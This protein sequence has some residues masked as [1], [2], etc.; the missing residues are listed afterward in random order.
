MDRLY[1]NR[2]NIYDIPYD[3]DYDVISCFEHPIGNIINYIDKDYTDYYIAYA[4]YMGVY[5]KGNVRDNILQA[6]KNKF[7]IGI[8]ENKRLSYR[9]LKEKINNSVPILVG[10]NLKSIWYSEHYLKKNWGHWFTVCGYDNMGEIITILDNMQFQHTGRAFEMFRIPYN[11]INKA[12]S[13]Y[14]KVFEKRHSIMVFNRIK[15]IQPLEIL[16][17]ILEEYTKL[18]LNNK[19]NFKQVELLDTYK[20]LKNEKTINTD[21]FE[22][23]LK[24][25]IIN[26]NK[27]RRL[28][29][30]ILEKYMGI[31]NF[32]KKMIE[33]YIENSRELNNLWE[34]FALRSVAGLSN[35]RIEYVELDK[36]IVDKE[37]EIQDIIKEYKIY[38]FKNDFSNA[39]CN[40]SCTYKCEN[41]N[42]C[43][44]QEKSEGVVFNFDNKKTYNW[45]LEDEAP[46]IILGSDY[47]CSE[48][49]IKTSFSID[50]EY[51]IKN[52][53]AGIFLRSKKNNSSLLFGIE[54]ETCI[55]LDETGISGN[56]FYI[57]SKPL[58]T[59]FINYINDKYEF[60]ISNNNKDDVLFTLDYEPIEDI[61]VGLVCKTWG[62]GGRLKIVFSNILV[63]QN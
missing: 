21:F 23:E 55:V 41:N 26:V 44:I 35:G 63:E 24:K 59:I 29:Q 4:K 56:K 18:D 48:L 15:H 40:M 43:V 10:V 14:N 36:K 28:F 11:I 17:N 20:R 50:G 45:W 19:D 51:S 34:I 31:Y 49:V 60:G 12:N 52:H 9:F 47:E 30:E 27:Y 2:V 42:D 32:D 8:S 25:K 62:S 53:E 1:R 22:N 33:K 54:N 6:L 46:K 3:W 58:Y 61:E 5:S 7:G 16:K 13:D 37:K 57:E 38:M 39:L